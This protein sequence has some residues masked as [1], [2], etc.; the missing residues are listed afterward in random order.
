MIIF[1]FVS[2][3]DLSTWGEDTPL[4]TNM[5]DEPEMG[6]FDGN[7]Y[8]EMYSYDNMSVLKTWKVPFTVS[9]STAIHVR[10]D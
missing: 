2:I 7:L 3:F 1:L 6:E 10:K 5:I 9:R 8:I 4:E